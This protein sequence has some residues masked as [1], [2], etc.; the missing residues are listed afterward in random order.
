MC[1]FTCY[2]GAPILIY[3]IISGTKSILTQCKNSKY[4][5]K[6]N[7]DGF[8]I[9]WYI[10]EKKDPAIYK[11]ILPICNDG[12][13]KAMFDH[14]KSSC[15]MIHIRAATHGDISTLNCHPFHY[16]NISFCHNG[17][18]ANFK[19]H[20]RHGILQKT[21]HYFP[22]GSTDSEYLFSLFVTAFEKEHNLLLAMRKLIAELT[23]MEIEG[24]HCIC[25]SDGE[26]I[27]AYRL[28]H[29]KK[30]APS[31][32]YKSNHTCSM[33]SSEPTD[34]DDWLAVQPNQLVVCQN[35]SVNLY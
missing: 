8:G 33:V 28:N 25:A 21:E 24:G 19:N 11:S 18:I 12:N 14:V 31:L 23:E 29:E 13:V 9:A 34:D 3:S 4:G 35:A 2:V 17:N 16:K 20:I 10:P 15:V 1:R 22:K 26:T 30:E 5:I 7:I 6:Y 27:I 32:F